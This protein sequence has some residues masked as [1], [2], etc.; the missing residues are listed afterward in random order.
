[1]WPTSD[2]FAA[3]MRRGYVRALRVMST[4]AIPMKPGEKFEL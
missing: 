1:M 3:S 4:T 2:P